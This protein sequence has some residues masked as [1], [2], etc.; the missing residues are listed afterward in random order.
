MLGRSDGDRCGR[1]ERPQQADVV[2][3]MKVS[4]MWPVSAR[5][6]AVAYGLNRRSALT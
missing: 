5:I 3:V 1:G 4:T 6:R 2:T